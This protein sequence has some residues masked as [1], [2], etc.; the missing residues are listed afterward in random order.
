MGPHAKT[1]LTIAI[2]IAVIALLI[3]FPKVAFAMYIGLWVVIGVAACA[4][5]YGV[6]YCAFDRGE[7]S[8]PLTFSSFDPSI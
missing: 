4:C 5:I 3:A 8:V 7:K 6:I 1:I 2:G